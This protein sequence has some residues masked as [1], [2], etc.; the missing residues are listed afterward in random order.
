MSTAHIL[1]SSESL[2]KIFTRASGGEFDYV[3]NC[4]G[5][6]RYSQED[7]VYRARSY[8]LSLTLGAEVARR[9]IAVFVECSTGQV[10]K[11]DSAPRRESDRT[12][13]WSKLAKWKLAAEEELAKTAG[14]NLVVLRL[15]NVY[16]PY[17]R[18]FLSTVLCMARVY[19]E[20]EEEMKW[21]WDAGLMTNTV[22]VEDVAGALWAA[23]QW[24]VKRPKPGVEIFNIVDRGKTCRSYSCVMCSL[25]TIKQVKAQWLS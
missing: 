20:K 2:S 16:G 5:E 24:G 10:Y 18:G 12:K 4:G 3:F 14:L 1:N 7:E 8:S 19:K 17:T 13:P 11:P 22:H 25:L 9:K 15:A 6:T 23:A 21:L